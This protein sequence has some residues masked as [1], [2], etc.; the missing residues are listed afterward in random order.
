MFSITYLTATYSTSFNAR[1]MSQPSQASNLSIYFT[2]PTYNSQ[3][4][5]L[6]VANIQFSGSIGTVYFVLVLYKQISNS[7][8]GSTFVN[9]RMN[10]A[11]SAE[12]VLNCQNWYGNL[13]DGCARAVYTGV[14]PLTVTFSGVQTN[15]LY[16]LYYL[17]ATEFPL[18]PIVSGTVTSQTII[19]YSG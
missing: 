11:P 15:S 3:T 6:T 18:R 8:N 10:D 14:S 9:I 2:T 12:Q 1:L 16:L 5:T 4:L 7:N 13:A 19:T 17:A